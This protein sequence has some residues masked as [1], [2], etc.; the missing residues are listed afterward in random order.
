MFSNTFVLDEFSS[1]IFRI[2][3]ENTRELLK[4][5]AVPLLCVYAQT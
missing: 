1:D 3:N 4:E 5:L 2:Y